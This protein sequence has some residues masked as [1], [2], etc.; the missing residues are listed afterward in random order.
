MSEQCI[1]CFIGIIYR[2]YGGPDAVTLFYGGPNPV[3]LFYGGPDPVT[4]F[5]G[6]PGFVISSMVVLAQLF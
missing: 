1:G 2:F 6:G 5:Y 3:T 4:L